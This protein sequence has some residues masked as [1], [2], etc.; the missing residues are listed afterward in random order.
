MG[1]FKSELLDG[2]SRKCVLLEKR[3]TP[4]P[5]GGWTTEWA[6]GAG[7]INQRALD[8]SMQ[9][10]IAEQEGVTSLYTVLVDKEFPIERGD[11]FRDVKLNQ[12]FRVTSDPEDT[13]A[14]DF[15]NL[16][17]KYFTAEKRALP[18]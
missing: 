11:Y 1:N 16:P 9:A 18:S 17:F 5:E 15:S 2:F 6:D 8:S 13:E 4:S 14:P 10:R 3:R 12:T 7:F